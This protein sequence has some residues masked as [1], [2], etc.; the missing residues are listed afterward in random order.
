[1]NADETRTLLARLLRG[2]A[3]EVDLDTVD[4]GAP[5]QEEAELDSMDF[6]NLVN[7]LYDETGI[8]IPERDYPRIATVEGF[9]GYV[10]ALSTTA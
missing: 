9:V 6:L 7:A 3:P 8:E 5:L 10:S 1:M 4:P 2:I